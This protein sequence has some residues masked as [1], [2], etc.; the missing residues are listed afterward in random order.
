MLKFD[1]NPQVKAIMVE[2]ITLVNYKDIKKINEITVINLENVKY[3][4]IQFRVLIDE[5]N[6]STRKL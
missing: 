6:Y 3:I 2:L 5:E 1:N 4:N